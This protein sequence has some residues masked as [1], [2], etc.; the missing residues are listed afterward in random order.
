MKATIVIPTYWT[1][2]SGTPTDK[3]LNIYDH[4]T[5]V[6]ENG[7]LERCLESLEKLEGSFNVCVIGTMTEPD[8]QEQF[9]EKLT[10]MLFKYKERFPIYWF[11]HSELSNFQSKLDGEGL[12]FNKK[13]VNLSGY[14]NI[15]NLCIIIPHILKSEIAILIDDDEV[16]TDKDFVNKA[17][18]YMGEDFDGQHI[19]GKTGYY[20]DADGN[21]HGSDKIS[22][23]DRFWKK[24]Y[25]MNQVLKTVKDEP[26]LKK[27][28]LALGGGM[29]IHEELF[30]KVAF[31][32]W[33]TRGEDI[34]YLVNTKL[35][36]ID[37]YL[38][39]EL[40]FVHMPPEKTRSRFFGCRQDYYRFFYESKKI[41]AA[42]KSE[43]F[44]R[45]DLSEL[46]P[47]PGVLLRRSVY[48]RA[49][50]T[51]FL[52]AI[53]GIFKEEDRQQYKNIK[54]CFWNALMYASQNKKNFFRFQ[55]GW[56]PFMKHISEDYGNIVRRI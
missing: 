43:L 27:T 7:T 33:I 24:G 10:G 37:F 30:N 28:P 38:D 29:V 18:E 13:Y 35:K 26:R 19:V 36:G 23:F 49:L 9:E 55:K 22:W 8:L 52:L 56:Q 40:F 53:R 21:H 48:L 42:F 2:E 11:S 3:L 20:I 1:K 5:P 47:Y 44:E 51:S 41:R 34:D 45:F 32:P 25:L 39:N 15:R 12:A 50:A 4:P 14:S 31:D 46:D 16:I 6:N 54:T 17:V